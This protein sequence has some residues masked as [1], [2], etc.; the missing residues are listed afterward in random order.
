MVI[1]RLDPKEIAFW[2]YQRIEKILD[3]DL[4]ASL[5]AKLMDDICKTPVL[6]PSGV[7][8]PVTIATLYRWRKA[9]LAGGL[10][11]LY[12]KPRKDRGQ[13]RRPLA[14]IVVQEALLQLIEDPQMPLTFLV[15]VLEAKFAPQGIRVPRTTLARRLAEQ[16]SYRRLRRATKY[17]R[18]RKRFVARAPHHIWQTD[19]KGPFEVRLSSGAVLKIHIISIIDDATRYVLAALVSTHVTIAEAVRVF[20]MAASRW[21]LPHKLY[22]DRASIFDSK[23][24]RMGLAMLGGY[25]IPV[26]PRNPEV[27]G[28][29]EAY[30]RTLGL[31]FVSRLPH[32]SVVDLVH[33]R[34]LFAAII[35]TLYHQ[36]K[37]RGLK[38]SP[39][40]A[41]AGQVSSRMVPP[42]QLIEA[43]R[44]KIRLKT[45]SKTGEVEIQQATYLVADHLRGKRLDFLVDPAAL[46]PPLVVDP[47]SAKHLGLER[48]AIRAQDAAD[49]PALQERRWANG[50]LQTLY[51]HWRGMTRP[52]AE[53]GFGLPELYALLSQIAGRFVPATDTE[54]TTIHRVYREIGPLARLATEE[55]MKAIASELGPG[56]PIKTYLDALAQRFQRQKPT[57]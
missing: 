37:H 38:M 27:R 15:A 30:H 28:K 40:K 42:S 57:P 47:H 29:I 41:L 10:Q 21:G 4:V 6:W 12:P 50:P 55:T 31:W 22:A 3:E 9:Y 24:F 35:E 52:Q 54:A 16:P 26:L 53:P 51:D 14:E 25:R 2:R 33:L 8:K 5:R 32:Q 36:H 17:Q 34:Q 20:R 23:A 43:F 44:K 46:A 19:S 11:A 48:A 13:P 39:E 56:R 45:H 1:K 49:V 7:T 18:R